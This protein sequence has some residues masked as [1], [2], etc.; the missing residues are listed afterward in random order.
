MPSLFNNVCVEQAS[1][2][3]VCLNHAIIHSILDISSQALR[4]DS[5]VIYKD[6]EFVH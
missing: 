3:Q 6:T 5:M 2:Y 1:K 4:P